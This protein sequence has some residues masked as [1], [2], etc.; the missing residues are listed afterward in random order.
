MHQKLDAPSQYTLSCM[1]ERQMGEFDIVSCCV[2]YYVCPQVAAPAARRAA[3]HWS[4]V[5]AT[6][7]RWVCEEMHLTL[8]THMADMPNLKR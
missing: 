2:L 4:R 8:V 3:R 1:F 5:T 6:L 7:T